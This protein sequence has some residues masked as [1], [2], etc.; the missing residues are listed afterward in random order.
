MTN[1]QIVN[2]SSFGP[3]L[4]PYSQATVAGGLVFVAGQVGL[5]DDNNVVAPG[6]AYEQTLVMLDR[7]ERVLAEVGGTLDDVLTATVFVTDLEHLDGLNRAWVKKFGDHRPARAAVVA[8]LL[9]DG[10]VVE[11]QCTAIHRAA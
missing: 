5:D 1:I 9:L 3:A 7:V 11:V 6:D 8:G 2:P 4:F 10:L